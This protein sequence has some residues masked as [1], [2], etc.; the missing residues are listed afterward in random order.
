MIRTIELN[1]EKSLARKIFTRKKIDTSMVEESVRTIINEV[2]ENKDQALFSLT[3]KFDNMDLTTENMMVSKQEIT[4]AYANLTKTQITAI[5]KAAKN[6]FRFAESQMPKEFF[7]SFGKGVQLGQIIR[8]IDKVGLYVPAGNYPLPSTVL[9][10]AIPAITAGCKDIIICTP[11]KLGNNRDVAAADAVI[12]AADI[13]GIKR[14]FKIGGAQA[15]AAMAH[16]TEIIPN[17][18][19]ITGPGNIYVSTAKKMLFGK[20]DIDIPAGPSEVMIIADEK[21]DPIYIAADMLAQAEHDELA[22]AIAV[23]DSKK[24]AE[25]IAIELEK[26]LLNL[27]KKNRKIAEKSIEDY[28][29]I[30][31]ADN[32]AQAIE[33]ANE[34]APEHL[35]IQV[36]GFNDLEKIKN[37]GSVFLG[38]YSVEAAGDYASGPNHTL[39]TAGF[40]KMRGGLSVYDYVKI[41]SVQELDKN[42]L[43]RMKKTITALAEMESLIAHR[44]SVEV[45]FED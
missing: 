30:V 6:I 2:K 21:A 40:A 36:D 34:F 18:Y 20:V 12:V 8:P 22:A 39:P 16:G 28:G 44:N 31:I 32:I 11:P 23:T 9:M 35:E 41:I 29:A 17:V 1:K 24:L 13:L 33:L 43:G 27:Q 15:I 25:R 10:T 26:Q 7:K 37:A 42:G 3:K 14:I 45:R 38:K 4:D 19:K 5:K